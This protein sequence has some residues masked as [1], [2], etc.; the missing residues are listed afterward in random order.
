MGGGSRYPLAQVKQLFA[1]DTRII[2]ATAMQDGLK[3]GFDDQDM[4]SIVCQE[5][6]QHHFYKS[7][8]AEKVPGLWQDVYKLTVREIPLYVKVQLKG[9]RAVLISFKL[10]TSA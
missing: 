10:D 7:M 3:L 1:L 6:Q 2:T 8:L 5:L 4:E 9:S